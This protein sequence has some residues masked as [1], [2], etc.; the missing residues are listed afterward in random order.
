M[1]YVEKLAKAAQDHMTALGDAA[2]DPEGTVRAVLNAMLEPSDGMMSVVFAR[3]A[4]NFEKNPEFT[5]GW[6]DE[7]VKGWKEMLQAALDET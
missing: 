6:V 7:I 5:Q 4:P 2:Y 1:T 3:F